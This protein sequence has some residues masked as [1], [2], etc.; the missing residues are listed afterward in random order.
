MT[1]PK[2]TFTFRVGAEMKKDLE[3]LAEET[4]RSVGWLIRAA[5]LQ[6]LEK[7]GSADK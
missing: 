4:G 1:D 7:Y 2:G 3:K 6:Y 5:I